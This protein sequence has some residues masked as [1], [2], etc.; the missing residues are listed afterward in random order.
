[1]TK[2]YLKSFF[3]ILI[4]A[5]IFSMNALEAQET[6][7]WVTLGDVKLSKVY[8]E[9]LMLEY[10]T[11]SYG[12]DIS[13][14]DGK[15]VQI[16]GYVIPLDGM[17]ISFVLSRNPN[18]TCFFCGG[19]GPETIVDIKVKPAAFKRYKMDER[20]TFKGILKLNPDN[21]K[22]FLYVLTDAEPI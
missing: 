9:E 6:I 7:D 1:M 19:G 4:L 14:F 3:S 16:S 13:Q 10:D 5:G 11:T 2:Q 12:T 21:S 18:A 22:S 8:S 15:E 17:G 20:S